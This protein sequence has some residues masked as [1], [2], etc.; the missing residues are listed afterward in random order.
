MD[1]FL[2][3]ILL[4]LLPM[5]IANSS[6]MLFGFG[7]RLDAGK[8]FI[9][10]KPLLGKGKSVSGTCAGIFFGTL[11]AF[12]IY[13]IFPEVNSAINANYIVFG[14]LLSLGAIFGDIAESFLKRRI[15]RESGAALPL[16]D[17]LD[18]VIGGIAFALIFYVPSAIEIAAILGITLIIHVALNCAAYVIG[19]KKV[20]W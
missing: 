18:F 8:N 15:G 1:F 9:D 7:R 17:Q 6:A 12:T 10:G 11:T 3:R 2:M 5:Y 14:F 19:V 13:V 20:P 4:Y 16:L